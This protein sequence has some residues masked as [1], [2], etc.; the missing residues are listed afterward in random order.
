MPERC[1]SLKC[2]ESQG[3]RALQPRAAAEFVDAKFAKNIPAVMSTLR[4]LGGTCA[5]G[6]GAN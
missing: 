6:L 4:A 2:T 5:L 3:E 1:C